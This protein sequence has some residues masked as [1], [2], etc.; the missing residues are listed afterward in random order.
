MIV[1]KLSIS[2]LVGEQSCFS[3]IILHWGH[4]KIL[5]CSASMILS[6]EKYWSHHRILLSFASEHAR[7]FS[8]GSTY[9]VFKKWFTMA[10]QAMGIFQTGE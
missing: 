4:N 10:E 6:H 8:S 3:S 2:A 1:L 9:I 5:S 7:T